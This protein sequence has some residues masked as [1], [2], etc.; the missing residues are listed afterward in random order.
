VFHV[1]LR[2]FPHNSSR[3]NL[4]EQELRALVDPWVREQWVE[5]GERKWNCNQ[6]KLTILEGPRL[7]VEQLAIGRGWRAAQR[8]STDVT[9]RV[10]EAATSAMRQALA[11][12]APTPQL[13]PASAAG[14]LSDPLALGVQI[15]SLL[16]SEPTRL[17][18]VWRA[19]AASSPGLAPS[20]SLALAEQQLAAPDASS[21]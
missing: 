11:T 9:E 16:G 18:E 5:L 4:S 1:E 19:A 12:P 21:G 3:F 2:Q 10:L 13:A 20:E 7:A 8:E 15:A 6:A 14:L 17:L